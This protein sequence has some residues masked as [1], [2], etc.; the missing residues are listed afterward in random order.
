MVKMK[1]TLLVLAM[2]ASTLGLFGTSFGLDGPMGCNY[3]LNRNYETMFQAMGV[4]V[5]DTVY[6][7]YFQPIG[8]DY[9]RFI[10][11][12]T[13]QLARDSWRNWVDYRVPD[14]PTVR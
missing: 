1:K 6:E 12:P 4:A 9:H 2:G 13:V 10:G 11:A 3:A 5:I 14:D 7:T 8:T